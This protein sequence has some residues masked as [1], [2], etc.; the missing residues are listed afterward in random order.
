MAG[1]LFAGAG[2]QCWNKE[3]VQGFPLLHSSKHFVIKVWIKNIQHASKTISYFLS[4]KYS[5][6]NFLHYSCFSIYVLFN[7]VHIYYSMYSDYIISRK[8]DENSNVKQ[9]MWRN[10]RIG[11]VY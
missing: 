6:T 5:D 2:V 10:A 3:R 8:D 11:S 9:F 4:S 1:L 7:S